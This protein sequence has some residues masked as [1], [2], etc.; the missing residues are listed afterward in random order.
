MHDYTVAILHSVLR[1]FSSAE[2]LHRVLVHHFHP[3]ETREQKNMAQRHAIFQ[4]TDGA[5]ADE[6]KG[7]A[8]PSDAA[9]FASGTGLQSRARVLTERK[10]VNIGSIPIFFDEQ[11]CMH[12]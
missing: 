12:I 11:D 8:G 1:S 2:H 7:S 3:V 5:T 9:A 4:L 10:L 6:E